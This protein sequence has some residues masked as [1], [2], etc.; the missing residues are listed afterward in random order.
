MG[1]HVALLHGRLRVQARQSAYRG[2]IPLPAD[3][4]KTMTEERPRAATPDPEATAA[5]QRKAK[6]YARI[7]RR[8]TMLG[9]ALG[10]AY[11]LAWVATGAA[12]QLRDAI[13]VRWPSPW[14]VVGVFGVIFGLTYELLTFPLSVYSG[15]IL[16]HRYG[17]SRQSVAQWMWDV[18]KGA[19]VGGV[20]GLALLE[21]LYAILRW[22]P[23]TWWL[24]GAGGVLAVSLV[25]THLG[26]VLLFPIFFKFTPLNDEELRRRLLALCARAG[27]RVRGVFTFDLG[28]KSRGANAALA[29]LG[30]TRRILL[31]D[32]LCEAYTPAEVE[33]VLAHEL[34]HHLYNHLWKGIAASVVETL[35]VFWLADWLLA[36]LLPRL[37]AA[38][39]ADVAGLPVLVLVFG[40]LG[41]LLMPAANGV[42][43]RF[44][45]Q[46][47][48]AALRLSSEPAAMISTMEKLADH[49][50]ADRRPHPFVTWWFGSHPPI[51]ARIAAAERYLAEHGHAA[52]GS[53]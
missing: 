3:T 51:D 41:I 26:P 14:I 50:L 36:G 23:E 29:G 17:Q 30:N 28:K 24:W 2:R 4:V 33:T 13:A 34:G 20:L 47:D 21:G 7:G 9:W 6:A 44:E 5:Q 16:P 15:Y 48:A 53:V 1:Y 18:A 8:L 31:S 25:L 12:P 42:S 49:N 37:G 46:A 27:T 35:G 11:T 22:R 43:R 38:G 32:T 52:A 19:A 45:R 39:L 40:A 10:A